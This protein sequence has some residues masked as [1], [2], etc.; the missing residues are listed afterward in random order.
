MEENRQTANSL[1]LSLQTIVP[2]FSK[3][4]DMGTPEGFSAAI[5]LLLLGIFLF[6]LFFA[7]KEFVAS[8]ARVGELEALVKDAD[9][10]SLAERR[11][12]LRQRAETDT[13]SGKLWREFD[14]SLVLIESRSRLFNT[15]DAPH[16]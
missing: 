7:L 11:R 2:D 10:E 16:F 13:R 12:E 14:E 8:R 5:V 3:V 9:R 1:E 6:G 4:T 15:I